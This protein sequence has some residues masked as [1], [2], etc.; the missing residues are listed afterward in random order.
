MIPDGL[1]ILHVTPHSGGSVSRVFLYYLK[2]V[3]TGPDRHEPICL[4]Y[5]NQAALARATARA[6]FNSPT[7][8]RRSSG[9]ER[10]C[11]RLRLDCGSLV[12]PP[13]SLRLALRRPLVAGQ[14]AFMVACFR[15]CLP[16]HKH[17][18]PANL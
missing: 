7:A 1:K 3:K 11:G 17:Q 15:L 2:A 4:D 18:G 6:P 10:G 5:A 8:F 9:L 13:P 16:R 12:E 14:A